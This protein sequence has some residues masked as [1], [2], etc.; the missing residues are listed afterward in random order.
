MIERPRFRLH[1][2]R[3]SPCASLKSFHLHR[4]SY[5]QRAPSVA[6]RCGSLEL[7]RMDLVGSS[8]PLSAKPAKTKRLMSYG[9]TTHTMQNEPQKDIRFCTS[10]GQLLLLGAVIMVLNLAWRY[11]L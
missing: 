11:V 4:T 10:V 6:R 1:W 3:V 5:I 9:E 7:R 2:Q 8:A